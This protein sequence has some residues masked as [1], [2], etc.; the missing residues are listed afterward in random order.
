MSK[1]K[2]TSVKIGDKTIELEI[3]RF[4]QQASAAVIARIGETVAHATI[5]MSKSRDDISW[6][7]LSVEYQEKLYAGG[8]IKGSRWVKRDGRPSDDVVLKARLIDRSIR[9][10]F[11]DGFKN[12]VQVI[13]TVLSADGENDADMAAMLA[14]STGLSISN[15]PWNGPIGAVRVGLNQESGELLLNPTYE[16][17]QA[18]D[19]DL[20]ISGSK[21]AVVMVEAGANEVSE[22]KMLEAFKLAQDT[23]SDS[24]KQLEGF[25]KDNSVKKA[26]YTP[27][28]LD[29]DFVKKVAADTKK[30]IPQFVKAW[31]KLE[32]YPKD[33][34]IAELFEKYGEEHSKGDIA[35]AIDKLMKKEARRGT[36]EEAT[37][38]DGRKTDEIREIT[39]DVGLLPR[40]HGSAMFKRGST[41]A[42]TI[43]TLGSPS[44]NQL[45][46]SMEG[47]EEKRY[48]HHY[49]MPPFTVGE[50]G[51]VGWPSR[52]EIGHGALA[53]RAL[54]PMIPSE[55][56][57]PY[58]IHVVSEIMS[59][60]GST[61]QASVCGS[62]LS[63]MDAGVP[64]KKPVSGIAMGL[65]KHED[66]YIVLSD[67]QGLEDFT[68]DMDFKVAGTKDGIT[69]MQMD[70]K[71]DGIP[72]DVL[73]Q[74]LEQARVGRLHILDKMLAA[75]PEPRT[76]LSKYAPK[77][78]T[79]SVPVD[80][81]GEIIGPGGKM[82]KSIIAETGADVD[83]NDDGQVFI[84]S[85]DAD[86]IAK[87]KKWVTDLVR[88]IEVGEEF[89]GEV[90]RIENY[91][92]FVN[93]I[94]GKDGLLHVSNMSVD[95]VDDVNKIV[96]M[97]DIIKV[98]VNEVSNEG[99][100]GLTT[101]TPAQEEMRN[102][103]RGGDRGNGQRRGEYR[104]RPGNNGGRGNNRGGGRGPRGPRR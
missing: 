99:K 43:T 8:K 88:E 83:I 72:M 74:A 17:R 76:T 87:A 46:E 40:T 93:L 75:L 28:L 33:E 94:P 21:E 81:I 42:L 66:Q 15:I 47:E 7:P 24:I 38:P 77:I 50:T 49:N 63:L 92:A 52:R 20:V 79:V 41:Q 53:E 103:S 100:I 10:L 64:L 89:E 54:E 56:D 90:V 18:S 14:V 86:A 11:P 78:E 82:I 1:I 71:I 51:R 85:A 68:G 12:E 91:G 2:T 45:I 67:I 104:G 16:Q 60:N 39:C 5:M 25:I 61:S 6:F 35:N 48:I 84:T 13:V 57:F 23:I 62:T 97:G 31:A 59:S 30:Q 34:L 37:R 96:S 101:L 58:T 9:P 22:S 69:A 27:S 19:L 73:T 70:I 29:E 44:L 36:I 80:R 32:S 26:E 65:L 102:A 55:E 4:A 95:Y 98:R 3:G